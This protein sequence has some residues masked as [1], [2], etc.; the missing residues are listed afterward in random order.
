M[1][2]NQLANPLTASCLKLSLCFQTFKSYRWVFISKPN[3]LYLAYEE[4]INRQQTI[5]Q[6]RTEFT[7]ATAVYIHQWQLGLL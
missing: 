3:H 6:N 1:L 5:A 4:S 2:K 7:L